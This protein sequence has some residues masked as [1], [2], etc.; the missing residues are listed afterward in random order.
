[1]QGDPQ[2]G[3]TASSS[4]G[5][6]KTPAATPKKSDA[7]GGQS[8]KVLAVVHSGGKRLVNFEDPVEIDQVVHPKDI[9]GTYFTSYMV[10]SPVVG[11]HQVLATSLKSLTEYM[12]L[13]TACQRTC[14][15]TKWFQM[16]KDSV[17]TNHQLFAKKTPNNEPFEFGHGPA[18]YSHM[19]AYLPTA[20]DNTSKSICLI[21]TSVINSTNDIPLLGSNRLLEKLQAVIDLGRGVV[22]MK[23]LSASSIEVPIHT[24]Y[25][26]LAVKIASFPEHVHSFHEV[27]HALSSLTNECDADVELIRI[28]NQLKSKPNS[29]SE[30]RHL[31]NATASSMAPSMASLLA[32]ALPCAE[33]LLIRVMMQ[34]VQ[35]RIR[36][37]AWLSHQDPLG[38][39]EQNHLLK[40]A[41]SACEHA[42]IQRSGN[43]HGRYSKCLTCGQKWKWDQDAEQWVD[44]PLKASR[45]PLPLPSSSTAATFLDKKHTPALSMGLVIPRATTKRS[46]GGDVRQLRLEHGDGSGDRECISAQKVKQGN[47]TWLAEPLPR[48]MTRRPTST[49]NFQHTMTG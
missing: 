9:Y 18:Q 11:L 44:P 26:H 19:H 1:L 27:L 40:R 42:T 15:S 3:S 20:F 16:W 34:A 35:L 17:S 39:E 4:G 28:H 48:S 13:D 47:K 41:M 30:A 12:V 46:G 31:E 2:S 7:K 45:V 14:C 24:V 29:N 10:K 8:K 6:G 25:G 32:G 21:G 49:S 38:M 43:K 23:G 22:V 37:R 36:P 5:K 33:V